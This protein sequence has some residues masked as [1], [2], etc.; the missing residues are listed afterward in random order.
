MR[1]QLAFLAVLL[2]V[3]VL[4]IWISQTAETAAIKEVFNYLLG[5]LSSLIAASALALLQTLLNVPE[6][7]SSEEY[8]AFSTTLPHVDRVLGFLSLLLP[9]RIMKEDA[10]DAREIINKL[11]ADSAPTWMIYT[12]LT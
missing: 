11:V 8:T 4:S 3:A 7:R 10:G 12:K 2:F 1:R 5:F 9:A 6:S